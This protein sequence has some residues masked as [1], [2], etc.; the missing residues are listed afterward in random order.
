M[1]T[2]T[3]I[4]AGRPLTGDAMMIGRRA[5]LLAGAAGLATFGSTRRAGAANRSR[6]ARPRDISAGLPSGW[7]DVRKFGAVGD[8]AAIDGPSINRA[9]DHVAERGGGTVYA[10]RS[11]LY[12]S[13]DSIASFEDNWIASLVGTVCEF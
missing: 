4:S 2:E 7:V 3:I 9:I 11:D 10:A 5:L 12:G 1:N 8:G 6:G 13:T